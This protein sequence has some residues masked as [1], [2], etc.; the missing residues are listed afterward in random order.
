[1]WNLYFLFSLNVS[2][3]FLPISIYFFTHL[4]KIQQRK[5]KKIEVYNDVYFKPLF[6]YLKI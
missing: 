5:S 3:V 4:K 6:F 1:M 2:I